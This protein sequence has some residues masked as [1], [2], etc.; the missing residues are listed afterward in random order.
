MVV[1]TPNNSKMEYWLPVFLVM[2][3]IFSVSSVPG[4]DI[5]SLFPSQ[6]IV[7]HSGIYCIL[8]F[9]FCNAL[10]RSF[11]GDLISKIILT[12]ILFG[13]FYGSTDEFHQSFVPGRTCSLSDLFVDAVGSL[14]GSLG[15]AARKIIFNTLK[16]SHGAFDD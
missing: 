3:L 16:L 11:P 13:I 15:F 12:A 1:S 9:F 6:D 7:F 2:I 14:T 8:A 10:K 4:N 5:P